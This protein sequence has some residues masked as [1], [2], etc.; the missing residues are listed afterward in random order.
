MQ[1]RAQLSVGA[2]RIGLSTRP[3]QGENAFGVQPLPK[4]V[5]GDETV[6]LRDGG[7]VM[8]KQQL[9][10]HLGLQSRHAQ[11]LEPA[12]DRGHEPE[13]GEVGQDLTTPEREGAV[14]QDHGLSSVPSV[15]C[16]RAPGHQILEQHG[17]NGTVGDV[18]SVASPGFGHQDAAGCTARSTGLKELSQVKDVR[19][20]AGE[21]AGRRVFTPQHVGEPADRHHPVRVAQQQGQDRSLLTAPERQP[22]SGTQHFQRPE[23]AEF[24]PPS[25]AALRGH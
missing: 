14:E 15:E 6:Q 4:R 11:L 17:I 22:G 23:Y 7:A 25:P 21:K 1:H 10:F 20:H 16:G 3:V 24:E 12:G 5:V 18:Q 19:L 8:A 13:F 9:S 2:Q